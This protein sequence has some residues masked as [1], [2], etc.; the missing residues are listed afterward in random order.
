M[1]LLSRWTSRE[2]LLQLCDEEDPQLFVALY[3]FFSGGEN[4]LSLKKG[5]QVS[6]VSLKGAYRGQY[7]SFHIIVRGK[8]VE[9]RVEGSVKGRKKK[10]GTITRERIEKLLLIIIIYNY[11]AGKL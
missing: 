1:Y 10:E 5:E 8:K 2:N 4:Q 11:F 6:L 3:D 7:L 9:K